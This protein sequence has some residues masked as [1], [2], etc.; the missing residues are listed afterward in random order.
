LDYRHS[1]D[2]ASAG[3]D[4]GSEEIIEEDANTKQPVVK[5]GSHGEK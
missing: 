3:S 1:T 5:R 4:V 2:S